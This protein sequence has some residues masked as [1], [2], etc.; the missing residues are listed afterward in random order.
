MKG[1]IYK[2]PTEGVAIFGIGKD[3]D[4]EYWFD[5]EEEAEEYARKHKIK[6][7]PFN[8]KFKDLGIKDCPDCKGTG[9]SNKRRPDGGAMQCA[10]CSGN[11]Q[12]VRKQK[13]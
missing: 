8:S 11:G 10:A 13:Y 7:P 3:V 1:F 12:M 6:L 4:K 2:H 5:T 9:L